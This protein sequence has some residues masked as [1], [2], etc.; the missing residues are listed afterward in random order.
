MHQIP[1]GAQ[2]LLTNI[3]GGIV[4]DT[5]NTVRSGVQGLSLLEGFTSR[6]HITHLDHQRISEVI[7]H[8]ARASIGRATYRGGKAAVVLGGGG[9]VSE[10]AI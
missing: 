4:A 10:G 5:R 3:P 1:D 7:V 6:V 8:V 9:R 2:G